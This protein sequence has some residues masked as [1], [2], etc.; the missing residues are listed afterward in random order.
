MRSN[1]AVLM[2][3]GLLTGATAFAQTITGSG[4]AGTFIIVNCNAGQS[5]N[6]TL[7][8]LNK[9]VPVEVGVLLLEAG[10]EICTSTARL[11]MVQERKSSRGEN[12]HEKTAMR[13]LEGRSSLLLLR[14]FSW[15]CDFLIRTIPGSTTFLFF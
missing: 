4:T 14:F 10:E 6:S 1:I 13:K 9:Q 7:S 12:G 2:A 5:L 11:R 3:L 15:L 8:M